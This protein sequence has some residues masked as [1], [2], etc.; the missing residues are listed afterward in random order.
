MCLLLAVAIVP[1]VMAGEPEPQLKL[2]ATLEGACPCLYAPIAFSPDGKVLACADY[3]SKEKVSAVGSVKLWDVGKRKVIATRRDTTGRDFDTGVDSV[4]FSPDGK[5]L[6]SAG[7]KG[8]MR[9]V[10]AGPRDPRAADPTLRLWEWIPP[11]KA[12]KSH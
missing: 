11:K 3:V 12:D 1:M 6:A 2:L 10:A 7:N 8:L 5:A 4:A 9:R